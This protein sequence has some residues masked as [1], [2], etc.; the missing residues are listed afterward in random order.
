[1]FPD[2]LS[3]LL[4]LSGVFLIAFMRGAFGG[5]FAIIGIP[6]LSLSLD[7]I[8]AGALL[9]PLFVVNDLFALRYWKPGTWSKPDLKLLV[10]ALLIG[11]AAGTL[12]MR[13]LDRHVI[14]IAMAV[15]TLLFAALWFMGGGKLRAEPRKPAKGL[16]AG[17]A[18]ASRPWSRMPVV[19]RLR[20]ICS[21]SGCRNRCWPERQVYFSQSAMSPR[22]DRGCGLRNR[23]GRFG[24]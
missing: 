9:A 1:M 18:L 11:I 17:F 2:P 14:E 6:L 3:L 24:C 15:I 5:G 10:P 12:L 7:P 20:C 8:A 22:P 16:F 21:R 19:R 13:M 4:A 23:V